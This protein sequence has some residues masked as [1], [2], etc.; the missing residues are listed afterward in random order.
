MNIIESGGD[1]SEKKILSLEET[2]LRRK[3]SNGLVATVLICYFLEVYF[4]FNKA[5]LKQGLRKQHSIGL[6]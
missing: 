5:D 2:R 1:T 4:S 3:E 6:L